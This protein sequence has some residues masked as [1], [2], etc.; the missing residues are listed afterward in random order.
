METRSLVFVHGLTALIAF[1]AAAGLL[2]VSISFARLLHAGRC[3]LAIADEAASGGEHA[4]ALVMFMA[5]TAT[6]GQL[7]LMADF[8]WLPLTAYE[9]NE[10][11]LAHAS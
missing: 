9:P 7:L 8:A 6:A 2:L 3:L 1:A 10:H 4:E 11:Q 5:F